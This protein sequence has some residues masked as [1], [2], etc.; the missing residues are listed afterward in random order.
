MEISCLKDTEVAEY[1]DELES[2][3]ESLSDEGHVE[4]EGIFN[5]HPSTRTI[6]W[7]EHPPRLSRRPTENIVRDKPGPNGK[8]K[9]AMT[10]EDVFYVQL[11][12]IS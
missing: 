7:S 10:I 2:F 3:A 8:C 9:T 4:E 11:S 1:A 12:L 6:P 5:Q